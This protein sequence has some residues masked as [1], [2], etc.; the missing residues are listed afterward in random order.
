[1]KPSCV[2]SSSNGTSN[3][4]SKCT[5]NLVFREESKKRKKGFQAKHENWRQKGEGWCGELD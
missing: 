3:L 1:M 2:L 4:A 5:H